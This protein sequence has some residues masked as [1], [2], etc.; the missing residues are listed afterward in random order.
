MIGRWIEGG[1]SCSGLLVDSCLAIASWVFIAVSCLVVD[2][3]FSS[4]SSLVQRLF[5]PLF[6]LSNVMVSI[7]VGT[8]MGLMSSFSDSSSVSIIGVNLGGIISSS[9]DSSSS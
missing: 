7:G 5:R 8:S 4:Y 3:M 1:W 9:S 2:R 6:G